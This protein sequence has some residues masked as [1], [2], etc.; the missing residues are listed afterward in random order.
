MNSRVA[1]AAKEN[2]DNAIKLGKIPKGTMI[3]TKDENDPEF[4]FYDTNGKLK[5]ITEKTRFE[6]LTDAQIWIKK[7]N[8]IGCI[9]TIHN[10][11]KW[12]PYL[13]NDDNTLV[14]FT[15]EVTDIG[16]VKTID[17]GNSTGI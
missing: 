15:N 3:I 12:L 4:L 10:G 2:I 16:N 1:Y 6:T 8:C 17:G 7:Y 5:T 9:F 13:V 14:L 11:T